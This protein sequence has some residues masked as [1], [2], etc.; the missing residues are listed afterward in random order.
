MYY[1]HK[2]MIMGNI[3]FL[4]HHSHIILDASENEFLTC[5][6]K[7]LNLFTL[8]PRDELKMDLFE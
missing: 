4:C 7:S 3:L 8:L 1:V 5:R 6:P 2:N